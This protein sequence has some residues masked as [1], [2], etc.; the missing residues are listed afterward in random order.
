MER[1]PV[2]AARILEQRS[3]IVP[4]A[5]RIC[6]HFFEVPRDY[7]SP[8]AGTLRLFARSAHKHTVPV[9]APKDSDTNQTPYLL[10]LQGGPGSECRAPQSYPFTRSFLDKGYA[11]FFL[12]QR[13]TGL[14]SP[15][16]AATLSQQGAF[17]S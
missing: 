17:T 7:S 1:L 12:D 16:T 14:S 4:G 3:H 5:L 9:E 6:E 2:T 10:Y 8:K 11:L 13:G 15:I